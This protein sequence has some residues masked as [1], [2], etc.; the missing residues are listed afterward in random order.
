M[1]LWSRMDL[2][3]LTNERFL[4]DFYDF[5][6]DYDGGWMIKLFYLI[7]VNVALWFGWESQPEYDGWYWGLGYFGEEYRQDWNA[8]MGACDW[9]EICTPVSFLKWQYG[10]G[11]NSNY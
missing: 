8:P 5:I 9:Q 6:Y 11:E 3:A 1:N 4:E 10:I 2:I 7:K